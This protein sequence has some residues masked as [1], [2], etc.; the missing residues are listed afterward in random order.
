MLGIVLASQGTEIAGQ[1]ETRNAILKNCPSNSSLGGTDKQPIRLPFPTQ[2]RSGP[3]SAM[4]QSIHYHFQGIYLVTI[5][6]F[7][8]LQCLDVV[9]S[10]VIVFLAYLTRD[11]DN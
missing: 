5:Y 3:Q 4:D 11:H 10:P 1:N 9:K 2:A 8:S 7:Y 6:I